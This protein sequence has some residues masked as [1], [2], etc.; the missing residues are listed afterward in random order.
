MSAKIDFHFEV[1]FCVENQLLTSTSDYNDTSLSITIEVLNEPK[2][3]LDVY[4][5]ILKPKYEYL[6]FVFLL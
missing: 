6:L 1:I 2:R 5:F 4:I 3:T